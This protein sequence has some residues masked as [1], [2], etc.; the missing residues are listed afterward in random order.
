MR[1][2]HCL[3]IYDNKLQFLSNW[4]DS[5]EIK[6]NNKIAIKLFIFFDEA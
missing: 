1:K 4:W 6:P 5:F 3:R 2:L